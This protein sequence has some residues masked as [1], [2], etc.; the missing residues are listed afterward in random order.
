MLFIYLFVPENIIYLINLIL[1]SFIYL[2]NKRNANG[3]R[4][5]HSACLLFSFWLNAVSLFN[6]MRVGGGGWWL[7]GWIFLFSTLFFCL[8]F[9]GKIGKRRWGKRRAGTTCDKLKIATS[10]KSRKWTHSRGWM[11]STGAI[12][13]KMYCFSQKYLQLFINNIYYNLF[14]CHQYWEVPTWRTD[15]FHLNHISSNNR[16]SFWG[17]CIK[18]FTQIAQFEPFSSYHSNRT[19]FVIFISQLTSY[20]T[21]TLL[22]LRA[23][24]DLSFLHL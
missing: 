8:F 23:N 19:L 24:I 12:P 4:C 7:V 21:Y 14:T 2:L 13:K 20:L 18:I 9:I 3:T 15:S 16:E 6:Q 11:P 17:K 10:E 22:C 5:L 1:F